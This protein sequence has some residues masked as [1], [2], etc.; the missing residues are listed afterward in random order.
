VRIRSLEAQFS[1]DT[2]AQLRAIQQRVAQL[3]TLRV[4]PRYVTVEIAR[5]LEAGLLLAAIQ[6]ACSA[7][8]LVVRLAVVAARSGTVTTASQPDRAR[9]ASELLTAAEE[10]QR[11]TLFP[12]V[13]ELVRYQVLTNEDAVAMQ[14][15]YRSVRIPL[16]HGIVGRYIRQRSDVTIS[17]IMGN[18]PA[19]SGREFEEQ[20]ESHAVSELDR[21]FDQV[22]LLC[23]RRAV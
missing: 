14:S 12:M 1:T 23:R 18:S 13:N 5:C 8:E 15:L 11:L 17:E 4:I 22:E 2:V 21:I 10:D 6:V 16:H 3:E 7:W 19:L 9:L 20:L